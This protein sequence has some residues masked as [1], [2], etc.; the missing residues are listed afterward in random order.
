MWYVKLLELLRMVCRFSAYGG[1]LVLLGCV[2]MTV[3]DIVMR[4]FLSSSILGVVELTQLMLVWAAF[5]TIPLSFAYATHIAV[6]FLAMTLSE[7]ARSV[8]DGI[9][10]LLA[11]FVMAAYAW[12]GGEQAL[13]QMGV[14]EKT[15]TVGIPMI[16]Y[17][18]PIIFGTTLSMAC[19]VVLFVNMV[20][21]TY[22]PA[23]P[24]G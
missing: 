12:W 5:M 10:T 13:H 18:V 2:A 9:G 16:W 8:L 6:D 3:A 4:N 1:A 7:R 15:L 11:A 23:R 21:G 19:A 14:G 17:W 20:A 24:R 22:V